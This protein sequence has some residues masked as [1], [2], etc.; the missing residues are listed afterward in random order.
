MIEHAK[1]HFNEQGTP[2]A[3][4]F[5]DVYFSNDDG[6]A[7]SQFVFF[8]Q[9]RIAERLQNHD[10]D[11]FV[12][13]ETGFGTGLNFLMAW[14]QF[15]ALK[16]TCQLPRLHFIS[17]EKFPLTQAALVQALQAWPAVA[18]LANK[19]CAQYP[20]ALQGCHRL[21][22]NDGE[23]VL[24]LW[25]GDVKQSL[26]QLS[27]A[28]DGIVDAWFLDGFAP[29]KN[30]EM[31]TADLFTA[32]ANLSRHSATLA[33][34]TAAG[35]VRR[36]LQEA[37]FTMQKQKGYGKKREMLVGSLSAPTSKG[38]ERPY[39]A[40]S[41]RSLANVAIIGGGIATS[42]L[43]YSLCKRGKKVSLFCKDSTLAQGASHNRQG[44]VYP[45][46]QADFTLQSE[47]YAHSFLYAKR[48][49]TQLLTDGFH[50]AHDWCGVL[51]QAVSSTIAERQAN[52]IAKGSWPNALIR[53]VDLDAADKLAGVPTGYSGLFI[54]QA[55]W[56]S[57][58]ELTQA[59][60]TKAASLSTIH[61]HFNTEIK[62]LEQTTEGWLLHSKDASF[63][64]FSDVIVAM[65]EHS[66]AFIQT[67]QLPLHGVR[68]QVSHIAASPSSNQ[69][70]TVL[71]HKGYFTPALDGQHCMGATFDK[72][73]KSRAV[74]EADNDTN[75][76]QLEGFYGTEPWCQELGAIVNAKAAVRCCFYDHLPMLGEVID[77]QDYEHAFAN[78]RKGKQFD[79]APLQ[80][81][82]QGLHVFT[83]LG[84][85]GLCSAPLLAE[86][87]VASLLGEPRPLSHRLSE[88]THPARFVI[89]A[90]LRKER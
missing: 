42:S 18:E 43:L 67:A 40:H 16:A 76:K 38:T 15:N 81:P 89:R 90:L 28:R 54:E 50:Y 66:D 57:P 13:A 26:P 78:L 23:V 36:G 20:M 60:F 4:L 53:A 48:L 61:S 27:Y 82:Q 72:H 51:I 55:G 73:S 2:V 87:L 88:A 62:R 71:C 3:D 56:V 65:G 11:Q 85:R 52:I 19:L 41:P 44:A 64:P 74:T 79:F 34:F 17:F 5:D 68:G 75:R 14:Q 33:T 86:H 29:S 10:R 47:M 83:G 46:L 49:Y 1:I 80:R 6:L 35:F 69:L 31:W 25:F 77:E 58:P 30:P 84:A 45:H 24:D 12:I 9:N 22:F 7:E 8:T 59:L 21:E 70:K 32:M 39:A 37:G 63:G